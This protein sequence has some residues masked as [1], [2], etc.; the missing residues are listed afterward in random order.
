M[1]RQAFRSARAQVTDS[2]AVMPPLSAPI[3]PDAVHEGIAL[4]ETACAGRRGAHSGLEAAVGHI[5]RSAGFE[6]GHVYLSETDTG[7]LLPSHI[8]Y[9][10]PP[11]SRFTGFVRTTAVS[12]L[13][14]GQGLPG[15]VV[16]RRAPVFIEPLPIS[17]H[18][19]RARAAIAS[20]LRAACGFPLEANARLTVVL[21]F[22]AASSIE[23]SGELHLL[24]ERLTDVLAPH[25]AEL[26]ARDLE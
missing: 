10:Q 14:P 13:V 18:M 6:V 25:L 3:P 2:D 9:L 15:Q 19:P 4:V 16:S 24:V 20:G 12:P 22:L 21:E 26:E 5:C 8:W 1:R 23:P 17:A 7:R 11:A